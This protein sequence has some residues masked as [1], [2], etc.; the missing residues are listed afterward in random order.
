MARTTR[1]LNRSVVAFDAHDWT[2]PQLAVVDTNVI[3]EALVEDQPEHPE[4]AR[5]VKRLEESTTIVFNRLMEIELWES[6]FNLTLRKRYPRKQLRHVRYDAGARSEAVSSIHEAQRRWQEVLESVPWISV[7]FDEVARMVPDLMCNYGFQSYD[8]V[9]VGTMLISGATD[10]I[11]RD[12]GFAAL[13]PEDAR[14]HT[15]QARLAA[16][17]DR[18]QRALARR[19]AGPL[20]P[21]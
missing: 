16:T 18:R 3:A 5:L 20:A 12:N 7:E 10:L 6:V 15:T 13:L 1:S 2:P 21:V 14:I 17:R 19:A 9:H 11:T 4:C 8:A